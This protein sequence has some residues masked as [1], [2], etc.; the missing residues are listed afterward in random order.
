MKKEI[1]LEGINYIILENKNNCLNVDE[2]KEKYTDYFEPYDYILGDYSYNKIRLKGFCDKNNK[3]FN[4]INDINLKEKYLKEL[5]AYEC[6]YFL[7]KKI[8]K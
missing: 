6:N 8:K 5:C 4:K 2:L 1:I 7:L 3:I